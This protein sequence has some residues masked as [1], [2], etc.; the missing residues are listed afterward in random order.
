MELQVEFDR[1]GYW[2]V[3]PG[4][5]AR[6]V[7]TTS[8]SIALNV[9]EYRDWPFRSFEDPRY[10]PMIES[11]TRLRCQIGWID[12]H[13]PCTGFIKVLIRANVPPAWHES[14]RLQSLVASLRRALD[15]PD[16]TTC[17][18]Y[19]FQADDVICDGDVEGWPV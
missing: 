1:E 16:N 8:C 5:F 6:V 12:V 4:L 3:M 18:A 10:A 19:C 11:G 15:I 14:D 7:T 2:E 13:Y 9:F 17:N